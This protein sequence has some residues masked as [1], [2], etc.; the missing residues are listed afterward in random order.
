M[1]GAA[2]PSEP[3]VFWGFGD[4]ALFVGIAF[5]A[6]LASA[7]AIRPFH[8]PSKGAEVLAAQ[9]ALYGL[10]FLGLYLIFRLKYGRPF[11]GPL[12]FRTEG[13]E[14]WIAPLGVAQAFAVSALG[15]A[16][17]TPDLDSPMLELLA[18]PATLGLFALFG[19]TLGPLCEE[20]TFRGFLQPLLVRASGPVAG[21]F[22]AAL[23]FGVL[24]LPQYGYSWRHALLITLAGAGFGAARHALGSTLGAAVMHGAYN[25]TFFLALL[26]KR[27]ELPA[28]W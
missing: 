28:L 9:F 3:D 8:I 15:A 2:A 13:V 26:W 10:L 17:R 27:G 18:D 16:L 11:W 14:W 6:A 22:A 4:V 20:L 19:S 25:F 7:L 12:G 24:H 23:P 1:T 21:V 5:L